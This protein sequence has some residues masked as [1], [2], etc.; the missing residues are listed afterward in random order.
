MICIRL[1]FFFQNAHRKHFITTLKGLTIPFISV[2]PG[3]LVENLP[4]SAPWG[5]EAQARKLLTIAS[6]PPRA[7]AMHKI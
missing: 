4:F 6:S 3:G 7:W 1:L 5:I 2:Y